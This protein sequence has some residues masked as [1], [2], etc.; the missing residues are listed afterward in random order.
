M[1]WEQ[2]LNR[3]FKMTD[4]GRIDRILDLYTTFNPQVDLEALK[5]QGTFWHWK[6]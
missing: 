6:K 1:D 5:H 2:I 3:Q 4:A